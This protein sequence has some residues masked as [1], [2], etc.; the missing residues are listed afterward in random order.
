MKSA[1]AITGKSDLK[2]RMAQFRPESSASENEG[3]VQ[4]IKNQ[5]VLP[6]EM[7]LFNKTPHQNSNLEANQFSGLVPAELGNVFNLQALVL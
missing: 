5:K 4:G 6:M 7:L 3:F 2:E 1:S